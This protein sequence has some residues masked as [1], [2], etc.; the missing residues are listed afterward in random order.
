M[1]KIE[2]N[3][4]IFLGY[5]AY[6]VLFF[7][8]FHCVFDNNELYHKYYNIVADGLFRIFGINVLSQLLVMIMNRNSA[9]T[10]EIAETWLIYS[11]LV[12]FG[13]L[14]FTAGLSV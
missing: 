1:K 3:K 10:Y 14:V 4:I 5:L 2:W 8:I 9:E 6:C 13:T 12:F 11:V 7:L